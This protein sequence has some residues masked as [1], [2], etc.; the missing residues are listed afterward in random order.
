MHS[1]HRGFSLIE[2]LIALTILGI[3][4][5]VS[6]PSYQQHVLRSYRSEAKTDL[7]LLANALEQYRADNGSYSDNFTE[8]DRPALSESG[9]YKFTIT[10]SEAGQAFVAKADALGLQTAD[11]EC[12]QFSVN[13][14]G[15]HNVRSSSPVTCWH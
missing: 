12:R 1:E 13:H 15:Q 9:R 7:L 2:L 10:L 14:Y 6:Y 11:T 5:A 8:L 3:L 4:L